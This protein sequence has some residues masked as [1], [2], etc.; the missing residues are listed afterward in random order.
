MFVFAIVALFAY[1]LS[2]ALIIPSLLKRNG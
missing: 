2:L 1:S